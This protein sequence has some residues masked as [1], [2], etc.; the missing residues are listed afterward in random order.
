[1]AKGDA[2]AHRKTYTRM[3]KEYVWVVS[4]GWEYEPLEPHKSF[5]EKSDAEKYAE[6]KKAKKSMVPRANWRTLG[7]A[8]DMWWTNEKEVV[9]ILRLE[10]R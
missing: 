6:R 5:R 4:S 3:N 7:D 8:D 1:V 10:L 9:R 2:F